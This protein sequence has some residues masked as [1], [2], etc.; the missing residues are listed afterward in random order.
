MAASQNN[1][2]RAIVDEAINLGVV[3]D[4]LLRI[5]NERAVGLQH[6]SDDS[7]GA[8][9]PE[10]VMKD[11]MQINYLINLMRYYAE[12]QTVPFSEAHS[13]QE[14]VSYGHYC[15]VQTDS[16]FDHADMFTMES[17]A[18]LVHLTCDQRLAA[19]GEGRHMMPPAWGQK[20]TM[21]VERPG[22]TCVPVRITR[23]KPESDTFGSHRQTHITN[24]NNSTGRLSQVDRKLTYAQPS[25][26]GYID[27]VILR[28][29]A[30]NRGQNDHHI[31]LLEL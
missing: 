13:L 11:I 26:S 25:D 7:L 14:K 24:S 17:L 10:R 5:V 21:T 28:S 18:D 27:N 3:T 12:N 29:N 20:G 22:A 4:D 30:T 19:A 6:P 15:W 8:Y 31:T 16:K 9:S 23:A 2:V 1:D